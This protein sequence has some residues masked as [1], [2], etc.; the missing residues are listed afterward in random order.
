VGGEKVYIEMQCD[1]YAGGDRQEMEI[2][3]SQIVVMNII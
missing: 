2:I 3:E 1:Y